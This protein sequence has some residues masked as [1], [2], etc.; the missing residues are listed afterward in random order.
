MKNKIIR[1]AAL[2]LTAA[3]LLSCLALA[4]CGK[5]PESG[6]SPEVTGPSSEPLSVPTPPPTAQLP[7]TV[8]NSPVLWTIYWYVCGSNLESFYGCATNDLNEALAVDM[9]DNVRVVIETGGSFEWHNETVSNGAIQRFVLDSKGLT[10]VD[11]Q[12]DADMGDAATLASFLLFCRDNFPSEHKMMLFW[13]HGGGSV[14]G[15]AFDETY[16]YDSLT[17]RE[18][19]SAFDAIYPDRTEPPF[20]LVGFDACLMST[21][22]VANTFRNVASYMVASEELEPG[23]GWQ[24]TGWLGSLAEHPEMGAEELGRYICDSYLKGCEDQNS[25]HEITLALTDLRKIER[26][27]EAYNELGNEALL[28]ALTDPNFFAHFGRGARV[29]ENYGGNTRE[30]GYSNMVD[31]GDLVRNSIDL[32][33]ETAESVLAALDDCVLYNVSGPYRAEAT[34]LSCYYSYNAD[35]S[36]FAS[37][38]LAGASEA[39]KHLFAY[40]LTGQLS[41]AGIE[42]AA[43]L[44]FT[45]DEDKLEETGNGLV[46]VP[47]GLG[48]FIPGGAGA[49]DPS[50]I[51]LGSDVGSEPDPDS[52]NDWDEYW[53]YQQEL[54]DREYEEQQRLLEEQRAAEEAQRQLEE[55]QRLEEERRRQQYYQ[56]WLQQQEQEEQNENRRPYAPVMTLQDFDLEEDMWVVVNEEGY[57]ELHMKPELADA[58]SEVRVKVRQMFLIDETRVDLVDWGTSEEIST[59]WRD[60]V[61]WAWF[62]GF[63]GALDG[64]ALNSEI[65]YSCDR[66]VI[67]SSPIML[68]GEQCN[69]HY[70]LEREVETLQSGA[71]HTSYDWHI[72]GARKARDYA[73]GMPDKYLIQLQ[74]GDEIIPIYYVKQDVNGAGSE[75][76][77]FRQTNNAVIYESEDQLDLMYD[78]GEGNYLIQFEVID[79]RNQSAWSEEV[80]VQVFDMIVLSQLF[81]ENMAGLDTAEVRVR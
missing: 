57:P 42:Y 75:W 3:V 28:S 65:C 4:G 26:L 49:G 43:G 2:V 64:V 81:R 46:Y 72:L 22:D 80:L 18:F 47:H 79:C 59:N 66:Y 13:N 52:D 11:E 16:G 67:Y 44:G 51:L 61:A 6:P 1:A 36:D 56:W 35:L 20:D 15:A 29:S 62:S 55:Q 60:G 76:Y 12:P 27:T 21:V 9:P 74:P 73:A 33:P 31:L 63:W 54:A 23:C 58:L 41:A 24:Y 5:K 10:L 32:F 45:I 14:T 78:F 17:L 53:Q 38:T 69:L 25:G 40:A 8:D 70:V 34:G 68:N 30:Q 48:T 71:V 77:Y 39:F 37:Y 7:E 19:A 50:L